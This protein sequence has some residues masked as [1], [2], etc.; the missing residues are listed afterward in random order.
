M[1][2]PL[3]STTPTNGRFPDPTAVIAA[4]NLAPSTREKYTRVLDAF[5]ATGGNITDADKLAEFATTLSA[6]RRAQLKAAVKLWSDAMIERTKA[7]PASS[8]EQV[9]MKQEAIWRFQSL[10]TAVT[11]TAAKGEKVHTWLT[12]AEVQA[13]MDTA[14]GSRLPDKRDRLLLALL[15]GAGLRREEA[16]GLTFADIKLQPVKGK[17]RTVLQVQGK[18]NK[19][20]VIPINSK[21]AALLDEWTGLVGGEGRVLRSVDKGGNLGDRLTAVAIFQVVRAHGAAI[22]RPKLAPHDLRRTYAQIGYESGIAITQISR[23]LGHSSV[24]TTQRYLN[25]DLD[26]EMTVSDFMPI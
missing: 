8:P 9:L 1:S 15:L 19:G 17:L 16:A 7:T 14:T 2:N 18:G 13:L 22:G 11:V 20:R 3:T 5:S 24:T 26:L 12:R 21:L 23:L 25:M 10:Q 4:A 6:S